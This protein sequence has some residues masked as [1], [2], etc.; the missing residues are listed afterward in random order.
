MNAPVFSLSQATVGPMDWLD[1]C[2]QRIGIAL[3]E[4]S[5]LVQ[6]VQSHGVDDTAREMA[7]SVHRFFA[8]TARDHHLDEERH[9]FPRLLQS[10]DAELVQATLR[11]R[12]DHGWLEQDWLELSPMLQTI[13][14]GNRG[15]DVDYLRE[16]V[17]VFTELYHD[18]LTLEESMIYPAA[19]QR[20]D[21]WDM[22]TMGREMAQ[23]RALA[24]SAG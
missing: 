16:S 10:S 7:R 19:R 21:A 9:V 17:A 13:A 14:D 5:A 11:L 18:H 24:R 20:M 2:H 8:S 22:A 3:G 15:V 4:L 23:R 6:R 12:Q 1:D